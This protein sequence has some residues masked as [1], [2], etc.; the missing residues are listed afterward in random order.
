MPDK[1]HSAPANNIMHE[2]SARRGFIKRA[3][4]TIL[5][6]AESEHGMFGMIPAVIVS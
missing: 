5:P 4:V 2:I 3:A 1:H 6:H